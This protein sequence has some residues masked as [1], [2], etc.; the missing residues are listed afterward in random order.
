[1][2]VWLRN[3][4]YKKIEE[5]YRKKN[6][7]VEEQNNVISNT[8]KTDKIARPSVPPQNQYNSKTSKK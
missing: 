3:F 7:Q 1:M 6:E 4:T 5:F 8:T 2:P